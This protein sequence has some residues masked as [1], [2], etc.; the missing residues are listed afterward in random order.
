MDI[1]VYILIFVISSAIAQQEPLPPENVLFQ[2]ISH[3]SFVLSWTAP[4][5]NVDK[6]VIEYF[7][8]GKE[9]DE[10]QVEI[11]K[12]ETF[13][14][15]TNNDINKDILAVNFFSV[16]RDSAGPPAKLTVMG[17]QDPRLPP[18]I[19]SATKQW[20]NPSTIQLQWTLPP[21]LPR[22]FDGL[23]LLYAP[24]QGQ[25]QAKRVELPATATSY[26]IPNLSRQN[27]YMIHLYTVNNGI[28]SDPAPLQNLPDMAGGHVCD[29]NPCKNDGQCDGDANS[30]H[31][32]ICECKA[33]FYGTLC[34]NK[35]RESGNS[36]ES[37]ESGGSALIS[38]TVLSA[39]MYSL[40]KILV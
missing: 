6:Y 4:P 25:A 2:L 32:Y 35:L 27:Q 21:V 22:G 9:K 40:Y 24:Q 39:V 5:G 16:L 18:K 33:G 20:I 10:V 19:V 17:E 26:Q 1:K 38:T 37:G 34:E 7:P 14:V 8:D 23:H 28:H 13:R 15:V 3:N 30:P 31:L 12:T 36:G 29:L 11:D